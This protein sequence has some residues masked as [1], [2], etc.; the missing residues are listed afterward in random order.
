MT[1]NWT[2]WNEL[3]RHHPRLCGQHTSKTG[4]STLEKL[5]VSLTP[6]QLHHATP[7]SR[8]YSTDVNLNG[9]MVGQVYHPLDSCQGFGS[10]VRVY[11]ITES[12]RSASAEYAGTYGSYDAAVEA[13]LYRSG[14]QVPDRRPAD[15]VDVIV[16]GP[17]SRTR[18]SRAYTGGRVTPSTDMGGASRVA[19]STATRIRMNS[20]RID[21]LTGEKSPV[22]VRPA[23]VVFLPVTASK[24]KRIYGGLLTVHRRK[25][26][27][28]DL[29]DKHLNALMSSPAHHHQIVRDHL[30]WSF[31]GGIHVGDKRAIDMKGTQTHATHAAGHQIVGHWENEKLGGIYY[32]GPIR[33][34]I[35]PD[36][37]HGGSV[38]TA[39][40]EF[41]HSLDY[42]YG[43]LLSGKNATASELPHFQQVYAEVN[44]MHD[45]S[46][47]ILNPYYTDKSAGV[48]HK[49]MWAEGYAAWLHGRWTYRTSDEQALLIGH[50]I[51]AAPSERL[52][53]GRLIQN[54]FDIQDEKMR[55]L[56]K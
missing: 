24:L 10:H 27:P 1:N 35:I 49:E 38:S 4:I 43:N 50:G 28:S 55:E 14:V 23:G 18:V 20:A 13:I 7:S 37:R 42:A 9:R 22:S 5:G 2:T 31:E 44:H 56:V 39:S 36:D 8:I 41:G 19:D 15:R 40:H 12:V 3:R 26:G 33:Q 46:Q 29:I 51:G 34:V 21:P 17:R 11:T 48:G 47:T 53:V 6:Y 52:R 54:Y 45:G 30:A 25:P 32:G 16:C